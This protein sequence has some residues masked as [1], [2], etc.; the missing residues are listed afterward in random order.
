MTQQNTRTSK[1]TKLRLKR[2]STNFIM[3]ACWE[4]VNNFVLLFQMQGSKRVPF[5]RP[6]QV[7][8]LLLGEQ[9]LEPTCPGKSSSNYGPVYMEVGDPR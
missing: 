6:G 9:L 1:W 5:G 4:P 7:G 3:S 2:N 8:F